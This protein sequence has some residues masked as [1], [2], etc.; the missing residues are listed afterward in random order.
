MRWYVIVLFFL[1]IGCKKV[2]EI[3][4]VITVISPFAM[5]QFEIPFQVTISGLV[6]DENVIEWIKIV[7]LD[8]ALR[9]SS[10]E[11]LINTNSRSVEFS[12]IIYLDNIH[13]VSGV[14]YVK[15]SANDGE[16]INSSYIEINIQE[17]PLVLK[18]IFVISTDNSQT[19]LFK[20]DSSALELVAQFSGQFQLANSV[21]KH[22]YIFIGTNQLGNAFNPGFNQNIWD[23]TFNTILS[24]YFIDSQIS[25]SGDVFHVCCSDG[26]I[27]SFT[28]NGIITNT[29]YSS[30]QDYFDDF[31]IVGNYLYVEE[32]SSSSVRYITVYFLESG[33]EMQRIPL[34]NNIVKI[35][36]YNTHQCLF[37]E[38]N[39]SDI[40]VKMYDR[41]S[42]ISWTLNTISN[43][44]IYDAEYILNKGLYFISN[45][46]LV[47][48][49]VGTNTFSTLIA[50]DEF[51]KISFDRLNENF[52][53][54]TNN[55]IWLYSIS[56][57][58][59]QIMSTNYNLEDIF[60]FYNK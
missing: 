27:R 51:K 30:N 15:V 47:L 40:E 25:E 17:Y 32:Y 7:V 2:D 6:E 20:I 19:N 36:K 43:D 46:G 34:L 35:L 5:T 10:E 29:V 4:P 9:P 21:S 16:N 58:Q 33:V 11:I 26:V 12:E 48:F 13:L 59:Y 57:G 24:T 3:P 38:Q 23:W 53:L 50:N 49:N 55:E 37:L 60:L 28:E 18:N 31:L 14:Y 22:Q 41:N 45:T 54:L 44:S 56:T 52:Y 42:N 39:L 8:D 1:I